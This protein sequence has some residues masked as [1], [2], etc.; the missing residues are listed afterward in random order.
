M[1]VISFSHVSVGEDLAYEHVHHHPASVYS[2]AVGG[3]VHCGISGLPL[4]PHHDC[5]TPQTHP[6][7]NL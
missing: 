6:H 5:P 4:H 3:E 7:Q 1:A 2:S